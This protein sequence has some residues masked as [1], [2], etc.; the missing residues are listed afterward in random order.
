MSN[1]VSWDFERATK[2]FAGCFP[3]SVLRYATKER[4]PENNN[5]IIVNYANRC[6][7]DELFSLK[8]LR[9]PPSGIGTLSSLSRTE[10]IGALSRIEFIKDYIGRYY[11]T[12][13]SRRF[14]GE[15]FEQYGPP[16]TNI[17]RVVDSCND[18]SIEHFMQ[19]S[20][21]T[22]LEAIFDPHEK[23]FPSTSEFAH[24]KSRE[25]I[26][27]LNNENELYRSSTP[28]SP[29]IREAIDF[30]CRDRSVKKRVEKIIGDFL[31]HEL[32]V[33]NDSLKNDLHRYFTDKERFNQALSTSLERRIQDLDTCAISVLL[34]YLKDKGEEIIKKIVTPRR[35]KKSV[36]KLCKKKEHDLVLYL[37]H[38]HGEENIKEK[39]ASLL[40]RNFQKKVF[41]KWHSSEFDE[42]ITPYMKRN[43][44]LSKKVVKETIQFIKGVDKI[45]TLYTNNLLVN[46][47]N[48]PFIDEEDKNQIINQVKEALLRL[49]DL[50]KDNILDEICRLSGCWGVPCSTLINENIKQG[51]V[52]RVKEDTISLQKLSPVYYHEFR[53]IIDSETIKN[54]EELSNKVKETLE[55]MITNTIDSI[56]IEGGVK[57]PLDWYKAHVLL[58]KCFHDDVETFLEKGSPFVEFTEKIKEL[59]KNL[60]EDQ[61]KKYEEG[62]YLIEPYSSWFPSELE[63]FYDDLEEIC[64]DYYEVFKKVK[65]D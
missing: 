61:Q 29:E 45:R 30:W 50:D 34:D 32:L 49:L 36:K 58:K 48:S 38:V 39:L 11:L 53:N 35:L 19:K 59:V 21:Y 31:S 5:V 26:K 63:N 56:S 27:R 60:P 33:N 62:K 2:R 42:Y 51:L 64:K 4:N 43:P 24:K 40:E 44:S 10:L 41:E 8:E 3:R 25:I 28:L 12:E 57:I 20:L 17:R 23:V 22:F 54:D 13:E 65:L 14:D 47:Y 1:E 37:A 15:L 9:S 55:V 46:I 6:W 16:L 18:P 7:L 52:K